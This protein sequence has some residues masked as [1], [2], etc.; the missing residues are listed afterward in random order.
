MKRNKTEERSLGLN[1]G[2]A[3]YCAIRVKLF[4][5]LK[6]NSSSV[7]VINNGLCFCKDLK[8]LNVIY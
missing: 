6:S 7:N 3:P 1:L 8:I 2:S 5:L 4:N